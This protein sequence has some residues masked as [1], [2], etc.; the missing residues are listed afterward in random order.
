MCREVK[1]DDD[2]IKD[3]DLCFWYISVPR[4]TPS[5]IQ[6]GTEAEQPS[7][8]PI[9]VE[10]AMPQNVHSLELSNV[11]APRTRLHSRNIISLNSSPI[12]FPFLHL[13][14]FF[15]FFC[16]FLFCNEIP[17][18]LSKEQ[19][20][21]IKQQ[22]WEG[23]ALTP[24]LEVI[25]GIKISPTI[26]SGSLGVCRYVGVC[27]AFTVPVHGSSTLWSPSPPVLRCSPQNRL[28]H[29]V[30]S[31]SLDIFLRGSLSKVFGYCLCFFNCAFFN[32]FAS[33]L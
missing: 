24:D 2:R 26:I 31:P 10:R 18:L 13:T 11:T 28:L 6:P 25:C 30:T 12:F 17:F 15:F 3:F 23:A 1:E 20:L 29:G 21:L 33:S 4:M 27:R 16:T 22:Q 7:F 5:W 19:W 14:L 32:Q 9:Q 8:L